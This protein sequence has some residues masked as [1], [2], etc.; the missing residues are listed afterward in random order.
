MKPLQELW[1]LDPSVDF[2]NHGSFGA[3]PRAVREVQ[4][5]FQAEMER[6]PV[7]FL[8]RELT[9]RLVLVRTRLGSFFG[10]SPD[11]IALLPNA[12]TG[13]NTV[14]W[15]MDWKPGDEILLADHAYNAVRQTVRALHDRFG[16]VER[17]AIVPFPLERPEQITQAFAEQIGPRTRLV[18]VDHITSATALIFPVAEIIALAHA[19]GVPVLV[20]GAH[21]PGMVPLD[22]DALGA[23]FYTGNLHK[24]VC[25]PKGAAFL[26]VREDW[27]SRVHPLV[28]SHGYG[29]GFNVE[30]DWIGT[31]DPSAWLS[32]P[33]ALDFQE[34]LGWENT[35]AWNH[36]LV[37]VGRQV[38]AEALGVELPHPDDPALYG[39]MAVIPFERG[40]GPVALNAALFAQH[41]IE[42]PFSTYDGRIWLRISGQRYNHA[43]QYER[44]AEVLKAGWSG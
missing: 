22:L 8:A 42:V 13:V 5:A 36:Q 10:A 41:R 12:S 18:L 6:E 21:A 32:V 20:D 2:L 38:I 24:W 16:V 31:D 37:Q 44:L 40:Q 34:A 15:G 29:Q 17:Q 28:I 19:A 7:R 1:D 39:S 9:A 33:A 35:R 26:Y 3:T 23:E 43:A 27:R 11:G 14:L 4:A 30:F 25:A